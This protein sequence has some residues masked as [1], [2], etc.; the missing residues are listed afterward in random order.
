MSIN[1]RLYSCAHNTTSLPERSAR[2]CGATS[3]TA[4]AN[5]AE[6]AAAADDDQILN[7]NVHG[8]CRCRHY[9]NGRMDR[10]VGASK[11]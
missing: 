10:I 8:G 7:R 4:T 2:C 11:T 5:A 3:T 1:L 6:V 9:G